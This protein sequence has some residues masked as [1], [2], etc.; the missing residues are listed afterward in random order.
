M[1]ASN[2]QVHAV[3]DLV[4]YFLDSSAIAFRI[5]FVRRTP[6]TIHP[7]NNKIAAKAINA[8]PMAHNT[9]YPD[10]RE[11]GDDFNPTTSN[12]MPHIRHKA[13]MTAVMMGIFFEG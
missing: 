6:L 13:T 5:R 11:L 2:C 10:G 4:E 3:G 1:K 12:V 7:H 8:T 9:E